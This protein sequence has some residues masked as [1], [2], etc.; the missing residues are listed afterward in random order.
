MTQAASPA[1]TPSA[2]PACRPPASALA[3]CGV[4]GKKA[5]AAHSRT[6][7]PNTG[8]PR[9]RT[10]RCDFA[11]WPLYMDKDAE[12]PV[13]KMFTAG[14]GIQVNYQE[15]IQDDQPVVRQ[16]P[17][18]ARAGHDIGYDLM[19]ITNG[20]QLDQGHR[21]GLPGPAGPLQA[22]ELHRQRGAEGTRTDLRPGN[23]YSS[24][25]GPA[26]RHRLR[27][28]VRWTRSPSM[29]DLWDP[30]FK[31]KVGMMLDTQ[32]VA[33]FGLFAAGHRPRHLDRGRL[34]QGRREAQAA[35]GRGLVRKY[36]EKRLRRRA[37]PGR[38]VDHPWPG[39][40]TSS[41]RVAEGKT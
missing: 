20:L 14:T 27:P 24:V 5:A 9:P 2:W 10:A 12:T 6:P 32:E 34:A 18:A 25:D 36:Y 41:S 7:S 38:R 30:K 33:N 16:G 40:V 17:A 19:V 31:G 29:E 8:P 37:R 21:A 22:A 13:L 1:V 28:R 35:E 15:V 23:I 11:N 4:K 39:R 26:H 3:A